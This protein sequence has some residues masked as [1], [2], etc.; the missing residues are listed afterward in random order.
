MVVTQATNQSN[1]DLLTRAQEIYDE[2]LTFFPASLHTDQLERDLR[3][4]A[5][6][7]AASELSAPTHSATHAPTSNLVSAVMNLPGNVA[8]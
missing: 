3:M 7:K 1:Q 4:R 2:S 8:Q 5:F 6:D